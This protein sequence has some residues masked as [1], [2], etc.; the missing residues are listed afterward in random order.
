MA[1]SNALKV[2]VVFE[3]GAR[4]GCSSELT[5]LAAQL[6]H[7]FFKSVSLDNSQ[8]DL[9]AVAAACIKLANWHLCEHL[10][11][12]D[13]ILVTANI[14]NLPD[15]LLTGSGRDKLAKTLDVVTTAI[16]ISL[17]FEV[18]FK[19]AR[20]KTPQEIS[21]MRKRN[22][23]H[24]EQSANVRPVE[25]EMN[26]EITE[27]EVEL[28]MQRYSKNLISP[29]RY[30]VHFLN[31]ISLVLDEEKGPIKSIFQQ[32]S[33]LAWIF[34]TDFFWGS[35]V[36]QVYANHIACACLMLAIEVFRSELQNS[37]DYGKLWILLDRKWNL[38]FCDD[39]NNLTLKQTVLAILRQYVDYER[40]FELEFST[41]LIEPTR[42]Y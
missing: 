14:A 17:N 15:E 35:R 42:T 8:I 33:N 3:A 11:T 36:L 16:L 21:N 9:Y 24:I 27:D 23:S 32:I 7:K 30:L 2:M 34:L 31:S 22:A 10:S 25:S 26:Y 29:H 37:E 41:Y 6:Y 19:D 28:L 39:L 38:I 20:Y 5:C 13:L 18:D 40:G 1:D 12:T 4:L